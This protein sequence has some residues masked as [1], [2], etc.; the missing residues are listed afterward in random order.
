MDIPGVGLDDH[1]CFYLPQ[2][3]IKDTFED[4]INGYGRSYENKIKMIYQLSKPLHLEAGTEKWLEENLKTW[5][6]TLVA[7]MPEWGKILQQSNMINSAMAMLEK[8][9]PIGLVKF[10]QGVVAIPDLGENSQSSQNP[11]IEETEEDTVDS[12]DRYEQPLSAEAEK[13]ETKK[14]IS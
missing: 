1:N 4:L 13:A 7:F 5:N 14:V 8:H 10:I 6:D 9:E 3:K 12:G 11:S 2:E